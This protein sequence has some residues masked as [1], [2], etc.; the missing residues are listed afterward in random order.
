MV[1]EIR[2]GVNDLSRNEPGEHN[3]G[4]LGGPGANWHS[5]GGGG[6]G[7]EWGGNDAM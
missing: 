3:S 6:G 2:P 4:H 7:G 1:G 5:W